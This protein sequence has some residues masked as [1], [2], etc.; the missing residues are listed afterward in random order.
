MKARRVLHP[1]DF[2]PASRAAFRRAVAIAKAERAELLIVHATVPVIPQAG[3]GFVP[4]NVYDDIERAIR[5]DAR[6]RLDKLVATAKAA[7]IRVRSLLLDGTPA[8][9]I[10]RAARKHRADLIVIGTHGRTGL[11]RVLL[12]SVAARVVGTAPC[13][14]LTVRAK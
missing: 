2:S 1:S 12:G 5:D 3:D 7:K 9:Q 6:Q 13:P 14:V 8:E 4:A 11:A 10:V